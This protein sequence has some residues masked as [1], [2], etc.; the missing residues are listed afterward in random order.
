MSVILGCLFS[1]G[2]LYAKPLNYKL[3]KVKEETVSKPLYF[4][5]TIHPIQNIPVISPTQG[6]VEQMNV[7]YGQI[8]KKGEKLLTVKIGKLVDDIRDAK[9]NYL[10][11]FGKLNKLKNWQSTSDFISASQ[12]LDKAKRALSQAENTYEENKTLF[13]FGVISQDQLA[14]SKD[15]LSDSQAALVQ[16]RLSYQSVLKQSKGDDLTI[17]ELQFENAKEKYESLLKQA[18]STTLIAPATGIVLVPTD[19]SSINTNSGNSNANT[20]S[21]VKIS[22]GSSIQYQQVVMTIGDM[23]GLK[24]RLQIPENNINQIKVGQAAII[25]SSGFSEMSLDGSV[26]EV[27][28]QASSDSLSSGSVPTFPVEVEVL[29]IP[30]KVRPYIRAGMDAQVA[31]TIYQK[32]NQITVPIEAVAQDSKGKPM[33]NLYNANTHTLQKREVEVGHVLQN[34]VQ[35][36][37]GLKAGDEIAL[38]M[39]SQ[40]S[41]GPLN[42]S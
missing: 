11:A 26:S 33:V 10:N 39:N 1:Q 41:S 9:V 18:K 28:A 27:G 29:H 15:A 34:Q 37:K 8:V 38:N 14:Q 3:F 20:S 42:A 24:I 22:S 13:K 17:A 16:A 30:K 32:T 23:S 35:I 2:C 5:G 12:A 21:S 19:T 40:P 36:L 7:T 4:S 31:I 25:T 6:V